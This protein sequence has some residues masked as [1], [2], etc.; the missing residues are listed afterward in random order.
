MSSPANI[1]IINNTNLKL[2]TKLTDQHWVE[3]DGKNIDGKVIPPNSEETYLETAKTGHSGQITFQLVDQNFN[4]IAQLEIK[5]LK[6]PQDKGN[7][8]AKSFNENIQVST[9]GESYDKSDKSHTR[10]IYLTIDYV[11]SVTSN[12]DIVFANRL[13]IVNNKIKKL[14]DSSS[15]PDKFENIS[16]GCPTIVNNTSL[17]QSQMEIEISLN[18]TIKDLFKISGKASFIVNLNNINCAIDGSENSYDLVIKFGQT[19]LESVDL[20]QLNITYLGEY[21]DEIEQYILQIINKAF[22]N[23]NAIKLDFKTHFP[24][25]LNNSNIQLAF[26][27]NSTPTES[28]LAIL[29][30]LDGRIG[31]YNLSNNVIENSTNN[32]ALV[33][34]NFL[35]MSFLKDEIEKQ[36]NGTGLFVDQDFLAFKSATYPIEIYNPNDSKKVKFPCGASIKFDPGYLNSVFQ[37]NQLLLNVNLRYT[38]IIIQTWHTYHIKIYVSFSESNG[39]LELDFSSKIDSC[40]G[41]TTCHYIKKAVQEVLKDFN[42]ALGNSLAIQIPGFS[43]QNVNSPSYIQLSG[44]MK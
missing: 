14:Y 10:K 38:E 29:I 37:N 35:I 9:K 8:V 33:L 25:F 7:L 12:W 2:L 26:V 4:S 41:G 30:G 19:I 32:S 44:K 11:N 21:K 1:T 15:L 24:K 18:G 40:S 36:L 27:S 17:S 16:I 6:D 34:S 31:T 39:N 3:D 5:S 13:A 28:F 42:K 22:A 20:S 43:I 23:C